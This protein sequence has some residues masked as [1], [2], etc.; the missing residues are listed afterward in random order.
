M[1]FELQFEESVYKAQMEL[2]YELGYSKKIKYYK[3]SHVFALTTIILGIVI[4]VNKKDVGYVF[5]L[6]GLGVLIEYIIFFIKQRKLLKKHNAEQIEIIEAFTK[7]PSAIF[8][9]TDDGFSYS[10]H[11]GRKIIPW[12]DFSSFKIYKDNIF[13]FTKS[14]ESYILGKIEIGSEAYAH[15]LRFLESRFNK[16]SC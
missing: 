8:E 13:L 11:K 14:F 10:D 9:F 16:T 4:V 5:I 6:L 12:S 1:I 15:L 2:L 3:N 7:N